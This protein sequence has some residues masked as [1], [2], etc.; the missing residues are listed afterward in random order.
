[1]ELRLL[2]EEEV[3]SVLRYDDLIPA[4]EAALV[5]LSAGR[6]LQPVRQILPVAAHDGLMAVMPAV[7]EAA[8]GMKLVAFYPG[9]ADKGLHTHH[10]VIVLLRPETGESLAVIDGRLITEM[11]TAAASAVATRML[12]PD[13]ASVLAI[14]GSGVQARSHVDA[15]SRVMRIEEIRVWSRT[16]EH[17]RRFAAAVGGRAMSAEEAVRDADVVVTATSATEPVLKG[18]WLR[19]GAHVNAVGFRGPSARELDDEAMRAVIVVDSRE[20]AL[21]ESGDVLLSGAAIH[22]E[23]GEVLAGTRTVDRAETTV[24]ESVGIAV[25]DL[26]A[27]RLV[28]SRLG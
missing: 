12:A 14:L 10:A 3:R 17:A 2:S 23:L 20:A 7:A 24:F 16:P 5:D 6:V 28:L 22:A 8:I 1:M 21:K 4:I 9:N 13:G 15:L 26:A 25:E 27:A 18:A 11:R 19:P